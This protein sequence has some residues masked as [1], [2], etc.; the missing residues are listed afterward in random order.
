MQNGSK[1]ARIVASD[2]D[3]SI[4]ANVFDPKGGNLTYTWTVDKN[5]VGSNT[6]SYTILASEL[7]AG[8]LK[9]VGLEVDDGEHKTKRKIRLKV[10]SNVDFI[11]GDKDEDGNGIADIKES[12]NNPNELFAGNDNNSGLVI[13][14]PAGTRLLAG[15]MSDGSGKLTKQ[16]MRDYRTSNNLGDNTD[17]GGIT[18]GDIYD[19]V[20]EDIET[21]G[22]TT[23]IVIELENPL[24]A[25]AILRKYRL[26]NSDKGWGAFEVNENNKYYSSN[27]V[28][29]NIDSS[30]ENTLTAGDSCL[31]LII[32][33]GGLND[34]DGEKNGVIEDPVSAGTADGSSGSSGSSGGSGGGCVLNSGDNDN[35]DP[36]LPV[37]FLLGMIILL[38]RRNA[39]S[40][41]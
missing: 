40:L 9:V 6:N 37:L 38:V 1:T 27:T 31:I 8:S 10:K 24:P 28:D 26:D 16:Q 14:S 17:D 7:T 41:S 33:D 39:N 29:C 23:T 18:T 13:V 5:I 21:I 20:I 22:G 32:E 36:T 4:V 30:T 15:S 3:V 34:A 25:G 19:Y 11:A 2:A 35:I 12:N